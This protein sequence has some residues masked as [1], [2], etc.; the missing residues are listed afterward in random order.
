VSSRERQP[1]GAVAGQDLVIC[2]DPVSLRVDLD[3]RQ[4]VVELHVLLSDS[5]AVLHGVDVLL[6]SV[7]R[8]H[9]GL[10]ARLGDK[11]VASPGCGEV[12]PSEKHGTHN[13]GL[14]GGNRSV[15]VSHLRP[16]NLAALD[17]DFGLREERKG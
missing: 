14:R 11:D 4:E 13:D 6:D 2:S 17:D 15:G 16:G 5:P 7:G 1:L 9:A 10:C 3:V 8:R 12:A